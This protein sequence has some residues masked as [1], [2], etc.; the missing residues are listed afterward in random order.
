MTA[1][2]RIDGRIVAYINGQWVYEDT[3]EPVPPV[4]QEKMDKGIQEESKSCIAPVVRPLHIGRI[5]H[6]VID[7]MIGEKHDERPA[8]I[9]RAWSDECA[10][11]QVFTDRSNDSIS[12][13]L[14]DQH[15]KEIPSVLWRTS[16]AYDPVEKKPGTWHWPN[17]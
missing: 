13:G 4:E 8:I 9:V 14:P 16:V 15:P 10:N 12:F 1:R 17:E 7:E 5:V 6:Y 11:M 2:S 3:G